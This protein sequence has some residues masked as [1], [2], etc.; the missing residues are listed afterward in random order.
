[1]RALL[2]WHDG[3]AAESSASPPSIRRASFEPSILPSACCSTGATEPTIHHH[4]L[5]SPL[6]R[7]TTTASHRRSC[8]RATIA[9]ARSMM[10]GRTLL[11][12][13]LDRP[14]V[15]EARSF[16][17]GVDHRRYGPGLLRLRRR[18]S[19]PGGALH[20]GRREKKQ[21]EPSA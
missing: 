20:K 18:R 7:H 5:P 1:M 3:P 9:S 6:Q 12:G 10:T 8:N 16:G 15:P 13:G 19:R 17:G 4:C 21:R 11:R 2:E 14:V